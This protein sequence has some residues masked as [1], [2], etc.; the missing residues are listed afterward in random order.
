MQSDTNVH[1][2]FF[3]FRS[4]LEKNFLTCHRSSTYSEML[5]ISP[6]HLNRICRQYSGLS[7]QQMVHQRLVSEIKKELRGNRSI[8]EIAYAFNFSDPSNFNRFFKKLS[9][10]TAQ[11]YRESF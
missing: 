5:R 3:R 1:P 7:A 9:G 6:T 2:D 11:Q 4:L 8:K 10:A